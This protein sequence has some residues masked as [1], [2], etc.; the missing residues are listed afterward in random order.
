MPVSKNLHDPMAR[1][2]EEPLT[3]RE[4]LQRLYNA[5]ISLVERIKGEA[6]KTLK[7]LE[8]LE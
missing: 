7:E 4:W 3:H 6:E 2:K 8:E 1:H 5:Q